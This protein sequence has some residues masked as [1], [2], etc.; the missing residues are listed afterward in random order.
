ML[1]G[2]NRACFF[3][4]KFVPSYGE[5]YSSLPF[6]TKL[7]GSFFPHILR[8]Y[9]NIRPSSPPIKEDKRLRRLKDE[10]SFFCC[11]YGSTKLVI[12]EIT[13]HLV[14]LLMTRY[15]ISSRRRMATTCIVNLLHR[16][17]IAPCFLTRDILV[18]LD[19]F[20]FQD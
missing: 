16:E 9:V 14:I 3:I 1:F 6:C 15:Y 7:S 5:R 11:F 10:Y 12:T 8:T 4:L 2:L 13:N 18:I 17:V 20:I 19:R